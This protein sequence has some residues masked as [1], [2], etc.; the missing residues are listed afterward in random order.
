MTEPEDP[1]GAGD[2][3]H[4]VVIADEQSVAVDSAALHRLAAHALASLGVPSRAELSIVLVHEGRMAELKKAY[5][6]ED[7][8]T[9]VLAFPMDAGAP[10]QGP[11]LLGDVVLC[12]AVAEQQAADAGHATADELNLL[13]VHGILHLLGHDH[14]EPGERAKM[15][16]EEH[17]IL[18]SYERVRA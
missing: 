12:P 6:G 15:Q 18:E 8:P 13:L 16:A 14:A 2:H 11:H 5:L 9:D 4:S 1:G 10:G 3:L 7:A 17:R